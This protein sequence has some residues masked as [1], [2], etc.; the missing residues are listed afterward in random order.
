MK[1][2][3]WATVIGILVIFGT[4]VYFGLREEDRYQQTQLARQQAADNFDLQVK[5]TAQA[6]KALSNFESGMSGY[7]SFS[8]ENHYNPQFNQC[9]VLI[10]YL[11][12]ISSG[13]DASKLPSNYED[14]LDAYGNNDLANCVFYLNTPPYTADKNS[15]CLIGNNQ[16]TYQEYI[17]FV[18][19]RME[20]NQ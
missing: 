1:R 5:C 9:Y 13:Q 12:N 15:S 8:E 7:H 16:A 19:Q 20:R 17:S 11:P 14:L 10:S 6:E 18:S 2:Y 4:A 3:V